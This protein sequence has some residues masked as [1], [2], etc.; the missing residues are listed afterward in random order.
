[1]KTSEES[2]VW[3]AKSNQIWKDA[4]LRGVRDWGAKELI[5]F[6]A[7]E[8]MVRKFWKKEMGSLVPYDFR[9]G[10]GNRNNWI[11]R[12]GELT[13]NTTTGWSSV[14]HDVG[15]LMAY[16]KNLRRP[17]CAEH[18]I[19]EWRFTKFCL[20]GG[21]IEQSN[22][23]LAA[24]KMVVNVIA[25]NYKKL[26]ARQISL[27]DKSRRYASNLSRVEKALKKVESSISDYQKQYDNERL[28]VPHKKAVQ[29]KRS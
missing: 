23:A 24:P 26:L 13:I 27:R 20:D 2:M 21:F 12:K 19:M 14:V 15:H 22:E 18:A 25:K 6:N 4:G 3:Y 17:H 1:M 10:S 28:T 11:N 29:R 8:S 5:D 16:A 7:A 9:Q